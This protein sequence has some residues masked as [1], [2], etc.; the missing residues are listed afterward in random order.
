VSHA[1]RFEK[2]ECDHCNAGGTDTESA[3]DHIEHPAGWKPDGNQHPELDRFDPDH[4]DKIKGFFWT[5]DRNALRA[6]LGR[7]RRVS[8]IGPAGSQS[9]ISEAGDADTSSAATG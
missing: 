8:Q 3:N 5:V 1:Y 2:W 4:P 9:A 6:H 7:Q